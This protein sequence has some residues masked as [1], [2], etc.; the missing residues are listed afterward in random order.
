MSERKEVV[1]PPLKKTGRPPSGKNTLEQ[2][3]YFRRMYYER[4]AMKE[5]EASESI[6]PKVEDGEH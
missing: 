4:K 2:R 6:T 5:A 1:V 3:E